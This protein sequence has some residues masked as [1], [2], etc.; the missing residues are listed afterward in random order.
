VSFDSSWRRTYVALAVAM[1]VTS[2]DNGFGYPYIPLLL[3]DLGVSD[4]AE[5][6]IWAGVVFSVIELTFALSAPL[7]GLLAD[8]I[9]RKP[10]VLRPTLLGGATIIAA[11][12]TASA[13]QLAAVLA[14]HGLLTGQPWHASR[15][16]P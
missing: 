13:P 14:L 8:R 10:M 4:P 12:F 2:L 6:R 9:G 15:W 1:S 16:R 11:T 3:R 7:W 5:E